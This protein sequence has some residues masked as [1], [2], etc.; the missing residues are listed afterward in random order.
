MTLGAA[1]AK[2]MRIAFARRSV[3]DEA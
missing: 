1:L 2:A 3:M